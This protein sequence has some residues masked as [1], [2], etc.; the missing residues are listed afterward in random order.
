MQKTKTVALC[1]IVS[2]MSLVA[3]ML[4]GVFPYAEYALPAFAGLLLVIVA[5]ESGFGAA[6][7]C[8]A[9]TAIL[10]AILVPNRQAAVLFISFLGYYP[11][12]KG[13]LEQQQNRIVEWICKVGLFNVAMVASYLVM[14]VILGMQEMTELVMNFEY[15]VLILVLAAN[16]IFIIYDFGVSQA[17]GFYMQQ[18]RTKI[19]RKM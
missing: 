15:G 8:F 10:A 13:K 17:I 16:V 19:F 14:T 7:V 6:G 9:A 2:G 5:L 4:T 1:G 11:L 18:I 3:M 12:L